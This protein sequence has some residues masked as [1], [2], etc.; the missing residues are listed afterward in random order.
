MN[1]LYLTDIN[2][3]GKFPKDFSMGYRPV[4]SWV[5][6]MDMTHCCFYRVHEL[7]VNTQFDIAI[8]SGINST[9]L[10]PTEV[11]AIP[12]IFNQLKKVAKKI[13]FHQEAFHR[14]F[15]ADTCVYNKSENQVIEWYK[16][17]SECDAILTHN[18]IDNEYFG[19]LFKK[20]SFVHPQLIIPVDLDQQ[21]NFDKPDNFI[22]AGFDPKKD[23]SGSLD[24][25]IL[26]KEFLHPIYIF[27]GNYDL[28]NLKCLEYTPDY[29]NFNVKLSEF[30]IGTNLSYFPIGGSFP[31]QCAMVKVPC[32]GWGNANP[33]KDC[34]PDLV[35]EYPDFNKL[36][37]IIKKLLTEKEFYIDVTE[38]GYENFHEKYS[39]NSY[40]DQAT[41]IFE[42]INN[43]K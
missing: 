39:Y 30:K 33:L 19:S 3:I 23:K 7:D 9:L 18:D 11:N 26:L 12:I 43:I 15:I 41:E 40:V 38:K 32:I 35:S 16:M 4:M 8:I 2:Y 24:G 5:A 10:A 6:A 21:V 14:S 20:P 31:L 1:I 34:F 36:R 17:V 25:Y 28:P 29:I 22:M 27:G 42:T 37:S 13:V